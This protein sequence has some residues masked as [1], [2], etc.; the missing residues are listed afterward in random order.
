MVAALAAWALIVLLKRLPQRGVTWR[1]GLANLRRRPLAS[2]LQIGALALGLMALLLLTVVRGDLMRNWRASLPPDAPNHF[3]VNVLPDQVEG[4]R[5]ALKAAT[6]ADTPLYPMVRGRLVEVNGKRLD[7][8]RYEDLRARRLAEREFNLS[9]SAELPG[10]NRLSAGKWFDGATGVAA[11]IS[12]EQGIVESLKLKLGDTLTYD[13]AGIPVTARITSLRK[14]D[15]DSF[16][17]NFFTLFA[18]G[19]LET[20]PQTYLG[21][22]RIP[23]GA[24]SAAWLSALVQQYPNV[25]AI[26]VG[27]IMRQV[28]SIIEQ[29]SRAV[30]FV[31]LFTLLGG[32]LVLQAAIAA[33]QDERRFDAAILRTL[34]ASRAQLSAA[35][36]AEFLVL[37]AL[38]G[39]LAAAGATATGY[40]LSDR[41]FQIPFSANP[42]VWLLGIGG[43]A[44]TVTLAG[45]L[46]TRGMMRMPPLAVIRQLG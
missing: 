11:G 2:S 45:W 10:T 36:I 22:A 41:V 34:G 19:V 32:L 43:G 35:Q 18:P 8:A 39:L 12:M 24:Q 16:R 42:I 38:A 28:Q 40:V 37:G 13:I 6:G 30:E 7:S 15:W 14:V 44:L 26:D 4:V 21:A 46:G 25:L 5:A 27:E 17:P 3:V 23:E 33:T 20:M 1:F 9:W 29:V 31:F